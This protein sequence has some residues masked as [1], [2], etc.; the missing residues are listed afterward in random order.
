MD[1]KRVVFGRYYGDLCIED[2]D[3]PCY[4]ELA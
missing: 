3:A 4:N 1:I 2:Y